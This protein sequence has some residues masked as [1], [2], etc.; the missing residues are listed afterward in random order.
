MKK[1]K[2]N[3][4]LE[5]EI[6]YGELFD[7][8]VELVLKTNEPQMVASTMMAQALRLYKTVFK[9]EGE[10]REVI[11]TVLRQAEN[12]EPYNHQTLH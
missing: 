12:I 3:K 11:E 5:L 7:K 4:E 2:K 9:H 10:F 1:N 6:I 8:M